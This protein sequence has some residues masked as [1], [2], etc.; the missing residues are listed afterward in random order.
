MILNAFHHSEQQFGFL[1]NYLMF[2]WDLLDYPQ[3]SLD[4][5]NLG[6]LLQVV[7]CCFGAVG[8]FGLKV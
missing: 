2:L 1:R 7:C 6:A 8:R 5:I 4:L 3:H